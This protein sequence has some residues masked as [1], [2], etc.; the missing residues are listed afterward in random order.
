[1]KDYESDKSDDRSYQ[2]ESSISDSDSERR[3]MDRLKRKRDNN[4]D[5]AA[6]KRNRLFYYLDKAK[7][8]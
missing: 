3:E 4:A 7:L 2:S 6:R 8:T 5:R 1:M